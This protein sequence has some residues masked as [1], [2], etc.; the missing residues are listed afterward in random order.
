M[1]RG[2]I[3]IKKIENVNS[4]QVTFSK[5]RAGLF[6]KANE[7]A[8]LCEA[9]LAVIIFSNTGKL[10]DFA[11]SSMKRVLSRYKKRVDDTKGPAEEQETEIQQRNDTHALKEEIEKL[12]LTQR[13][14]L[15]KD[16]T[17]LSVRELDVLE[18]QLNE[19]LTCIRER[20]EQMLMQEVTQARMLEQ[21]AR[22]ENQTLRQ[23]VAELQ[24]L[25]PSTSSAA[26]PLC[27][28]YYSTANKS[29]HAMKEGSGSPETPCNGGG[30]ADE[31]SDTT[32]QLGLPYGKSNKRKK[33]DDGE[34]HS[35]TSEIELRLQ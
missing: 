22:L 29:N 30:L 12:K 16:I 13:R 17:G 14:L 23:Q 33:I 11:S 8:V 3:E 1:G 19:G 7:L 24:G 6:K 32:L 5:R 26:A 21:Q 4:R 2:K 20:K 10:F 27:I 18:Q 31:D 34:T 15:G 25:Y 28:E 35:T 9:E